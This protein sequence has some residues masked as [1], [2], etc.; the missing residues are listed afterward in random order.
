[1]HGKSALTGRAESAYAHDMAQR[2][3]AEPSSDLVILGARIAR[4]VREK[5]LTQTDVARTLG[6]RNAT[7]GDWVAGRFAPRGDNLRRLAEVLGMTADE[8]LDVTAGGDPPFA[9]WAA[10]IER[11]PEL[12]DRARSFLRRLPWPDGHVP[13]VAT[14]EIMLATFRSTAT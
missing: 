12:D 13:T 14:Y 5:G 11:H 8:L 6:V 10:F 2:Q 7:V 9:S 4:A 1:M 3:S